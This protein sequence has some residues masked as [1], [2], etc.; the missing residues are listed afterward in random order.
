MSKDLEALR[1]IKIKCH[2][3]S[4]PS[5]VVDEALKVVEEA[6]QRLESIE[7]SKSSEAFEC[8]KQI[9]DI[10]ETKMGLGVVNAYR[11]KII[12]QELN[13]SQEQKNVL[14]I[15][16]ELISKNCKIELID[17]GTYYQIRIKVMG[18]DYTFGMSITK[19]E[20]DL[21]KKWMGKDKS[22]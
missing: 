13:E 18:S 19:Q 14:E 2:P 9:E 11:I 17:G 10:I 16:K 3:N 22:E 5:P 12:K 8:L 15:I 20:F 6:L 21:L 7:S 4:N 1:T